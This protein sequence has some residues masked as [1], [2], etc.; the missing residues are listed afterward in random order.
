MNNSIEIPISIALD[1]RAPLFQF[2]IS[3]KYIILKVWPLLFLL[4]ISS[5]YNTY[6]SADFLCDYSSCLQRS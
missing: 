5:F 6:N 1:N 2:E 3:F 4:N